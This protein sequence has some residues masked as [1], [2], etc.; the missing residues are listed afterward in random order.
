VLAL[1]AGCA[2]EAS[3]PRALP[4][5]AKRIPHCG[6]SPVTEGTYFLISLRHW[7]SDPR[8]ICMDAERPADGFGQVQQMD[9]R[10]NANQTFFLG[11]RDRDQ[12]FSIRR[13]AAGGAG[14]LAYEFGHPVQYFENPTDIIRQNPAVA[15]Q[16]HWHV[17]PADVAN[18][19]FI[20]N[21]AT[22]GCIDLD[23]SSREGGGKIQT[24]DCRG[25]VDNQRWRLQRVP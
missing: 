13:G 8:D 6:A 12:C 1:T 25:G 10:Q 18:A 14:L 3:Q 19:F 22:G 23:D 15:D 11:A 20:K 9:C 2:S 16:F 4:P 5:Q 17:E 21:K 7:D 24:L